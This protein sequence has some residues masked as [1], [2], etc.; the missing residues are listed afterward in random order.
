MI[1]RKTAALIRC[2]MEMGATLGT[3]D[4]SLI[5]HMRHFGWALGLAFQV[6]DDMLGIWAS[7]EESGKQQAGDIYRR[8]KS[9]PIVH[10]LIHAN[11]KDRQFLHT[12]YRQGIPITPEQVYLVLDILEQ[13]GSRAYCSAFLTRQCQQARSI[14]QT[15]ASATSGDASIRARKDLLTIVDFVEAI[16]HSG[17]M[18]RV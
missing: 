2:A 14:L 18:Q 4:A 7:E 5:E 9:L 16:A 6:R 3:H 8:K 12:M 17:P 11:P 1:E 10:A 13:T 15:G